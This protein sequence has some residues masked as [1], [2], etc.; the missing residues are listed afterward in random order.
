MH[1][2]RMT[3]PPS[4]HTSCVSKSNCM[5]RNQ[6]LFYKWKDVIK[7]IFQQKKN[8]FQTQNLK[9]DATLIYETKNLVSL[10]SKRIIIMS[11]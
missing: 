4:S 8:N 1:D 11:K 5:L 3:P 9:Y 2:Y 10:F 7:F 6:S